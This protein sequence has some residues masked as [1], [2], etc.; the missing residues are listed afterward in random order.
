MKK[1][2]ICHNED[3]AIKSKRSLSIISLL[4]QAKV[5]KLNHD[6]SKFTNNVKKQILTLDS[7]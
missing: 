7:K 6:H 1:D 2:D 3:N 5:T 4:N